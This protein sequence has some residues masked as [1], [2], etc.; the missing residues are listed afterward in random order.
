MTKH[1]N[2][3]AMADG[4]HRIALLGP[5][6]IGKTT[7]IRALCGDDMVSSDV[8]NVDRNAHAK[9]FTTVGVE[10]GEIDL[11]D[12][13]RVELWGCPGQDRF[14][15]ARQWLISVAMGIFIMVD[16]GKPRAFDTTSGLLREIGV[17]SDPPVT[18]ILCARE[19]S[20]EQIEFFASELLSAGFGVMPVLPVDVRD[21]NQLLQVL[22]VLVAMLSMRSDSL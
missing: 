11:G 15:F 12:G 10:F 22:E 8:P 4:M 9:E 3:A 14:D 17:L 7:A 13:E 1:F 6:G 16:L 20:S 5:M 19:A 21:R 18:L 2:S